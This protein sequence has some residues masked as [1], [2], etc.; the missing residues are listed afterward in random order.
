MPTQLMNKVRELLTLF[1]ALDTALLSAR[2]AILN[3]IDAFTPE[4][5]ANLYCDNVINLEDIPE[6]KISED[7]KGIMGRLRGVD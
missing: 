3:H 5:L 6:N 4:E 7:L 1:D 2:A